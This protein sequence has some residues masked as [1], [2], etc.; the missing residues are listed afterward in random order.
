MPESR[1][2]DLAIDLLKAILVHW[3]A[4]SGRSL[5]V[6]RNLAVR[7]EEE[8]RNIGV[9]PDIYVVEPAPPEGD[10]VKSLCLWQTGHVAP[11][12]AVEIVS[13]TNPRKDYE[14]APE[15]YAASGTGE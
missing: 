5:Q 4:R 3:A 13:A 2:H 10:S 9:D 6:G 8:S 11:R 15:K 7:W 12:I 14:T 1:L